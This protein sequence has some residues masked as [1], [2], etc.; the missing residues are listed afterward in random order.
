MIPPP[1]ALMPPS[2]E[3]QSAPQLFSRRMQLALAFLVGVTAIVL[4]QHVWLRLLAAGR[5]TEPVE[6]VVYVIDLNQ[7]GRHE[8]MQLPGIGEKRADRILAH[9]NYASV[10]DLDRVPGIGR[11][12]VERLGP[13]VKVRDES[14]LAFMR[15]ASQAAI[16]EAEASPAPSKRPPKPIDLN[17]ARKTDLMELPGIGPVL[18]ER[19][20]ADRTENGPFRTVSDLTRVKGIKD[21]MLQKLR[22]FLVVDAE[23]PAVAD[24]ERDKPIPSQSSVND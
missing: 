13:R 19:I 18:A 1:P 14:H 6:S 20:V 9:R 4:V 15:E 22:P 10:D 5:P 3:R 12:M 23:R 24:A 16:D 17:R 8:L 7:A 21:K 2:P 11:T